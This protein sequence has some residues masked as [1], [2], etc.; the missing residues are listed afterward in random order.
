MDSVNSV[1]SNESPQFI[2]KKASVAKRLGAYLIDYFVFSF[3]MMFMMFFLMLIIQMLDNPNIFLTV[4]FSLVLSFIF[5]LRDAIKGQSLGKRVLGIAVRDV[6]DNFEVPSIPRLFLRQLF[7]CMWFI[8]FL[9]LA[10]SEENRKIGDRLASTGVYD[11]REYESF[12][13]HTK[14]M[15]HMQ[16]ATDLQNTQPRPYIEPSKPNTRK[17]LLIIGGVLLAIV[18]FVAALIFGI[19]AMITRHPSFHVATDSVRSNSEI[20]AIVGD[21]ES[22][23]RVTGGVST[24]VGRGDA[25]FSFITRGTNGAVRVFVE[26]EMRDGG[27]WE[28]RRFNF[29]EIE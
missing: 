26:L 28:I 15:E 2:L 1:E 20:A 25:N 8:E 29:V 21:I 17:I 16:T 22:F 3:I 18:L 10:F 23:N 6:S 9:V 24:S 4:I 12:I 7:T 27:D 13:L 14:R 5:C 11:L 19:I